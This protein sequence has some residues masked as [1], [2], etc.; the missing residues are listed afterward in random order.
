M[1]DWMNMTTK[2]KITATLLSTERPG[3]V[4]LLNQMEEIGYFTA[5][6]SGG[7]HLAKEGGLAEH[8]WNVNGIMNAM[9]ETVVG[10]DCVI[11]QYSIDIVSLLH[12]LGKCGDYGKPNYVENWIKDGRPTK[13]EPE[14]K[15]K[16]SESKP[17][18]TNPDLLYIPHEV[19]SVKI[20]S[21]FIHLTEYEEQAIL[22]H[23]GLYGDFRYAVQGNETPLYLLLHS[24]DMWAS[25]VIEVEE[26]EDGNRTEN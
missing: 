20:A 24:A 3:M 26:E 23:N 22:Y 4:E 14:Q 1:G 7:N 17:F 15:Y 11:P 9:Y 8:S 6:C 16:I 25:R 18:K 19:R 10:G 12:D 13:A 21:Q 5:P 2:E